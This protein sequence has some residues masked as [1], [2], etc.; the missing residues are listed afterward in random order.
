MNNNQHLA[1]AVLIAGTLA[2]PSTSAQQTANTDTAFQKGVLE[3]VVVT[4]RR[5]SESIQE[6]PVAVTALTGDDLRERGLQNISDLTK[7]VP[8]LQISSPQSNQVYIRGIGERTGFARVDP[9]VGF[10]MNGLYLPQTETALLDAI[11]IANVQVL[12]GPQGTLFGKNTTGGAMIIELAPPEE[13]RGGYIE[14]NVGDYGRRD[15]KGS[16]SIP[17]GDTLFSRFT[18]ATRHADGYIED[19][20]GYDTANTDRQSFIAQLDWRPSDTLSVNSLLFYGRSDEK[21][22]G[23]NCKINNEDSLV[24]NGLYIMFPGDTDPTNP[25]AWKE[26][27]EANDQDK[28]GDLTTN[29]GDN[30]PIDKVKE[31][32]I[33]MTSLNWSLSETLDFKLIG[34]LQRAEVEGPYATN[35][36]DA[37]PEDLLAAYQLDDSPRDSYSIEA[38]FNG[39][40][41]DSR[42]SYSS[43]LFY[44]YQ[45]NEEQFGSL[46]GIAGLDSSTLAQLGAATSGAPVA[47][48]RP[49]VPGVPFVGVF[50]GPLKILDFDLEYHT[51]AA[52]LQSSWD[53]TDNFQ[54]TGGIRYTEEKRTAGL[55]TISADAEAIAQRIQGTHIGANGV[56]IT[57]GPSAQGLH[58]CSCSW[59]QDPVRVAF[60][61][62]PDTDGDGVPNYPLD[63]DGATQE[64]KS[65]V[66]RKW[67]PMVSGLYTLDDSISWMES[68]NINSAMVYATWSL[69]FKSGF[70]EPRG[71]DGLQLV[72]PEEVENREIGLKLDM[73]E[74]SLRVN[75]AAYSMLFTD[76]QLL[77]VT[78]D[79][80]N[81]LGIIFENAAKSTI[82]GVELEVTWAASANLLF[83]FNASSNKYEFNDFTDLDTMSVVLNR[84]MVIDRSNEPF[85]VSP[86][87]TVALGVEYHFNTPIGVITPRLDASYKSYIYYGLDAASQ[88]VFEKNPELTGQEPFVVVDLRVGWQINDGEKNLAFWMRNVADE[89]YTIG[90][91]SA[92]ESTG[93]FHTTY[94]EPRT[95][96]LEYRQNFW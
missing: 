75:L 25:T 54:L 1:M 40:L 5:R 19:I 77:Q 60:D 81:N 90:P 55:T 69:G 80:S 28:L 70:F 9:T 85:A 30:P 33:L 36:P 12:R 91:I 15:A 92:A 38:Q 37:G 62:F 11:D 24:Q 4:A 72:E 53:V 7:S 61:L 89:R 86:E 39:T 21:I 74:R 42:V 94:G 63:Y 44:M 13:E 78:V 83:M 96:G 20:G 49:T 16:I 35:D 66:F 2:S 50:T 67:T 93:N 6:T 46:F 22:P 58:P 48:T 18:V 87:D 26:N 79:S 41:F 57:F 47:P 84:P 73:L 3:E 56:P 59:L 64:E 29:M 88:P 23:V 8:S 14:F 27:C 31:S 76:Q 52:Y 68:L 65:R 10:Y 17:L 71:V 95:F 45:K 82:E 34:G 51:A 32:G 43:G